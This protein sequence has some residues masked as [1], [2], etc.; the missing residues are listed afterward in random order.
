MSLSSIPGQARAKRF[1]QQLFRKRLVPHALL[2][3]GLA[4]VGKGLLAREFAGLLNC[5]QPQ[6]HDGC[7]HCS[8]CRKSAAGI[9]PDLLWVKP[10]GANIKIE[11]IRNLQEQLRFPPFEGFRRVTILEDAHRLREE[12]GNALLKL[13][14]EP[15]KNNVLILITPEPQML[16]QTLVSRCCHVRLQPLEKQLIMETLETLPG[17]DASTVHRAARLSMGSLDHARRFMEDGLLGRW[18]EITEDLQRIPSL[19]MIELFK[20][21]ARWNKNTEDLEQDIQCMKFWM[22][23]VILSSLF[24]EH[25]PVL[26]LNPHVLQALHGESTEALL[27]IYDA[28]EAATWHLSVNANKQL[29]IEGLCLTIRNIFHGKSNRNQVSQMRQDISF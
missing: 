27:E 29:I 21:A 4:G 25:E 26:P 10:D 23:D 2:F 8:S 6:N 28:L 19:S 20:F 14:E 13:L 16:L 17:V 1:L 12:A 3:S 9:H 24:V 11:Q 7:N 18:E 15:P 22:R 5:K